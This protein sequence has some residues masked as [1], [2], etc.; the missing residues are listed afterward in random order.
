MK[1]NFVQVLLALLVLPGTVV[2]SH[3]DTNLTAGLDQFLTPPPAREARLHGPLVY[4]VRPGSPVLYRIPCTGERP[5]EFRAEHLPPGLTLNP[6]NGILTGEIQQPGDY[7]VTWF[8]RNA[9]GG[10]QRNF[11]IKVGDQLALTPPMGWNSWYIHFAHVTE[12]TMRHA[13][14]A[15]IASGMADFGY[16]YVNI[17]DGWNIKPGNKNSPADLPTR[18]A[19]GHLLPNK[20]FPD[21]QGMV[22]YLHSRGLKAGIYIS[23]G[24]T[25]C[26]GFAGSWGHEADD[27]RTFAG[28]GFDFLKY[29]WCSYGGHAATKTL[30]YFQQPYRVMSAELKKQPRDL[31]FNLCQYGM[32]EVWQWG[33]EVGQCWRTTGDLGNERDTDLP[34]F[35]HIAFRNAKLSSY[36]RPGAWNDPDYLLLGWIGGSH[37]SHPTTLTQNEQYSYMSLW[38]LMAAPLIFSGDMDRLDAFTLNV[39]CNAEVIDVDQDPLGRQGRI[40]RQTADEYVLVRELADGSRAVGLFNLSA[41][42]RTVSVPLGELGVAGHTL[43]RDLWRQQNL[44]P[45]NGLLAAEVP[46]HGVQLRR[47]QADNH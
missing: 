11:C 22:A 34:G 3:A 14:D 42:T 35:Y 40:F 1:S 19:E 25:T 9:R 10:D 32:A 30:A 12:A 37:G 24:P 4:G 20:N 29:D 15:M 28:W 38:A 46:P 23:P 33:G 21:I 41:Q 44:G 5:M 31:V 47:V 16:Q 36:A 18:D 13:A 6:T 27:A 26:A 8:A 43:V 45:C 2:F 39:L 17:D 7:P